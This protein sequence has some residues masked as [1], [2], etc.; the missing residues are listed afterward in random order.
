VFKLVGDDTT[1]LYAWAKDAGY[2]LVVK[3]GHKAAVQIKQHEIRVNG[4]AY[5]FQ[6]TA[7]KLKP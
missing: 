1:G 4:T 2:P 6:A 5:H 7:V 3:R